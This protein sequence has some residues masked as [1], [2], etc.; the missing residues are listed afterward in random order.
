MGVSIDPEM[1]MSDQ[2]IMLMVAE[3][4]MILEELEEQERKLVSFKVS[5]KTRKMKC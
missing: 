2:Q 1:Q 3:A 4:G 5:K